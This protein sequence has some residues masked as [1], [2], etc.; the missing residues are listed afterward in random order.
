MAMNSEPGSCTVFFGKVIT[1]GIYR[2]FTFSKIKKILHN[3]LH[4][5][6]HLIQRRFDWT[7]YSRDKKS[8]FVNKA[9][10][11]RVVAHSEI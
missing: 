9:N 8:F 3:W 7:R 10:I 11:T 4:D 1:H 5:V 6:I 2:L